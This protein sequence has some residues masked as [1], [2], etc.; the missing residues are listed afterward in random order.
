M[1]K[2]RSPQRKVLVVRGQS[3]LFD[4]EDWQS[5]DWRS[6]EQMQRMSAEHG[7]AISV[8]P[9]DR[10]AR[11]LRARSVMGVILDA[12][13]I[14]KGRAGRFIGLALKKLPPDTIRVIGSVPLG[15]GSVSAMF[16]GLPPYSYIQKGAWR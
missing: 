3:D 1:S 16:T 15:I 12:T 5:E 9:P 11:A 14:P 13:T 10:L 4:T 8:I 6:T 2:E 7:V